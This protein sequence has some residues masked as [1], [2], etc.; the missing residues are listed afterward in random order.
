MRS[1]MAA[2][3]GYIGYKMVTV[4]KR[5]VIVDENRPSAKKFVPDVTALLIMEK[6][7]LV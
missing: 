7:D 1:T 4:E 6:I 2:P 3:D 5:Y